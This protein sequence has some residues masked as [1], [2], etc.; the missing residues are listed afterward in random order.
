MSKDSIVLQEQINLLLKC[1]E[2]YG[3]GKDIIDPRSGK[4]VKDN[5]ARAHKCLEE[6]EEIKHNLGE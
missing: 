5:G 3:C 2:W 4:V 6:F 1:V